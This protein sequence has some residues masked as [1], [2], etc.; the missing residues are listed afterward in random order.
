MLDT[1]SHVTVTFRV[2]KSDIPA[3]VR[4][5]RLLKIAGRA[6]G[7]SAVTYLE[8]AKPEAKCEEEQHGPTTV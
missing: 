7:L 6:F 8:L 5:R 3:A 1:G 2:L 4:L